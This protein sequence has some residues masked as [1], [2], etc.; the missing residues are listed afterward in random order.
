LCNDL[1]ELEENI[2]SKY[3]LPTV[4]INESKLKEMLDIFYKQDSGI[5]FYKDKLELRLI[6]HRSNKS[7]KNIIDKL[8]DVANIDK[9]MVLLGV[10]GCGKTSTLYSIAREFYALYFYCTVKEVIK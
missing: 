6:D 7:I 2:F 4:E 3:K 5:P 8:N 1:K 10:S 9:H